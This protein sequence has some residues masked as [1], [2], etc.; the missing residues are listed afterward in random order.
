MSNDLINARLAELASLERNWN[1]YGAKPITGF[2]M[3]EARRLLSHLPE[4]DQNSC[5]IV[6]AND[7]GLRLEWTWPAGGSFTYCIPPAGGE[8]WESYMETVT[9]PDLGVLLEMVR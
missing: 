7:G 9:A 5:W 6:P 2:A 4:A 1:S 3:D 8:T